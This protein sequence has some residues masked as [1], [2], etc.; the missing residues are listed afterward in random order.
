VF[1]VK[2]IL[3]KFVILVFNACYCA[4]IWNWQQE[5]TFTKQFSAI[6]AVYSTKGFIN[7]NG[8]EEKEHF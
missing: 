4:V 7:F 8:D 5:N 1:N 3:C 6:H 2:V